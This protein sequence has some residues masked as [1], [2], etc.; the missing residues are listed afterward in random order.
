MKIIRRFFYLDNQPILDEPLRPE[1][2]R[3]P[4]VILIPVEAVQVHL[5]QSSTGNRPR[6]NLLN[7][8]LIGFRTVTHLNILWT[9]PRR[10]YW[11]DRA[12]SRNL[13]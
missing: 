9:Q 1:G 5:D 6:T 13:E 8:T 12:Q 3:V 7:H 2:V 4:P 11:E 10:C